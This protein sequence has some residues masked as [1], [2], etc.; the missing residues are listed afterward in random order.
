M[1]LE[2][3]R[4]DVS[5]ESRPL[6]ARSLATLAAGLVLLVAL[7]AYRLIPREEGQESL[8]AFTGAA[9][10]TVYTVKVVGA[11]DRDEIARRIE[12]ELESVNRKMSTYLPDSEL[13]R[14]NAAR[15][16]EP[17]P[18]S[19]ATAR[20]FVLAQAVSA[21]SNGA[22]DITVG[23]LV[24]L[25]GFGPDRRDAAPTEEE[26]EALRALTGYAKVTVDEAAGTLR[27]SDPELYCDLSAIAKG[28]GVDRVAAAL[29]GLGLER[30]MI[31]VGGEVRTRGLNPEG[32]AWRIGIE[33]PLGGE[34]TVQRVVR[35]SGE[36]MA[37]SGDYRNYYEEGGVRVSHTI[38]PRTGRPIAHNLA[39]VSVIH[40]TCALADA[41]ATALMV[42]GPHEGFSLAQDLDLAAV[43]LVHA[44]DGA[45][46]ERTT[47]TFKQGF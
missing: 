25:W 23:P 9:M 41:Y 47:L 11:R 27:K 33:K 34:R 43:F 3:S 8:Q 5:P 37:T 10:G 26:I 2:A 18:V 20:V 40:E 14:F 24:N 29:D 42:L 31:E 36:S 35:L 22:F 21:A 15:T 28:F 46:E 4:R 38:D 6:N 1:T 44:G 13:S 12:A 32:E 7:S 45:F 19:E 30:Y 16:T 17:F 39:S